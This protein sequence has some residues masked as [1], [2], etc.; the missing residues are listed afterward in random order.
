MQT[1]IWEWRL[2]TNATDCCDKGRKR[3]N[4]KWLRRTAIAALALAVTIVTGC[5]AIAGLDLNQVLKNAAKATSAESK[6]ILEL[7][8]KLDEEA[9]AEYDE[10]E[11]DLYRLLSNIKLTIEHAA[12][13]DES[14]M[15]LEGSLSLGEMNLPFDLRLSETSMLIDLEGM[16]APIV[17]DL[18]DEAIA[19][20][21][22]MEEEVDNAAVPLEE[23]KL[24]EI[25]RQI[26]DLVSGYAIDNLPNPSGLTAV[27]VIEQV[28]GSQTSMM[29]LHFTM[30]GPA[31]WDWVK[32]YLT[33]L[34][35]DRE[36]LV[37]VVGGVFELLEENPVYW[38]AIGAIAPTE[39]TDVLD[40][41]TTDEVA[42][43]AVDDLI[44]MFESLQEEMARTE[45]ED[46]EML[47]ELLNDSLMLQAD[48]YVD[49]KLDIRKQAWEFH[50]DLTDFGDV[51]EEE[52]VEA[53]FFTGITVKS[54]T[55][56]WNVGGSV[57]AADPVA[58]EEALSAEDLADSGGH[59][60]LKHVDEESDLYDLLKNKFHITR[61]TYSAYSDD[62]F[63]P[64]IILPNYHTIV[65]VRD[66]ADA[67]GATI[68]YH[69]PTRQ[70]SVEDEITDTRIVVKIGSNIAKV[71]GVEQVWPT[72]VTSI[73][74]VTY[75]PARKLA[76]ALGADI[77][78]ETIDDGWKELTITREP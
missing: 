34:T 21:S 37:A 58:A 24:T 4:I 75:V 66:V 18:S 17:V 15:S 39:E 76:E 31:L 5:Q 62:Y 3:M 45:K 54:T 64:P 8:L 53:P 74:G 73:D 25:G 32:S 19:S 38:E 11:A 59:E 49:A 71:N 78:W 69:P 9:L 65:A 72:T 57:T 20:L 41:P 47:D 12:I 29:K 23:E 42:E 6:S 10:S 2:R 50:Y 7:Q 40:A 27:P 43:Q 14:N 67:F 22:G 63:N 61:Q 35:D 30:D 33:A 48:V 77:K 52:Y 70:I 51:G 1:A 36:G 68:T 28:G 16:E 56:Q 60:F 26:T 13:E 46:K 55:E 44:V